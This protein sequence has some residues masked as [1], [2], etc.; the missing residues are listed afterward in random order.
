M[1]CTSWRTFFDGQIWVY[2]Y[3]N[4]KNRLISDNLP[5]QSAISWRC[6]QSSTL[7][8]L[9]KIFISKLCLISET[10]TKM[11]SETL[12]RFEPMLFKSED[13]DAIKFSIIPTKGSYARI[14]DICVVFSAAVFF[15]VFLS[16]NCKIF[17]VT[18]DIKS[19]LKLARIPYF[20]HRVC[21]VCVW[22][23]LS[24]EKCVKM[25][26]W[27]KSAK[28]EKQDGAEKRQRGVSYANEG[29]GADGQWAC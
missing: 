27:Q 10:Y 28:A 8:N 2:R 14:A 19:A 23:L 9:P 20:P 13:Q 21:F 16:V 11:P 5:P 1:Y 25:F 6:V 15:C 17:D 26:P 7:T 24:Y 12:Q 22:Y 18:Q 29:A 4:M 3:S